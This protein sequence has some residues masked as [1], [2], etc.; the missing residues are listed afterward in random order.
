MT[1]EWGLL[2]AAVAMVAALVAGCGSDGAR[3]QP[4][5]STGSAVNTAAGADATA[6]PG[7]DCGSAGPVG[8]ADGKV[9]DLVVVTGHI[10]C[11]E[12]LAVLRKYE[13]GSV[14]K[15]GSGGFATFD[16]WNCSHGSVADIQRDGIVA[17]CERSDHSVAFHTKLVGGVSAS[18]S[19]SGGVGADCGSYGAGQGLIIRVVGTTTS[20]F[21]A[22]QVITL[23]SPLSGN[24]SPRTVLGWDCAAG[25][26]ALA[27][28]TNGGQT[29]KLVAGTSI[30]AGAS[31]GV[32][33][34]CGKDLLFGPEAPL[35]VRVGGSTPCGTAKALVD[36][37]FAQARVKQGYTATV[38]G[39][40]C[41]WG[42][43]LLET[44]EACIRG[45][46]SVLLV[47]TAT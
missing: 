5:P 17:G 44:I 47:R 36:K 30:A 27:R 6:G 29:I 35:R 23:Y 21:V 10:R 46:E 11:G 22:T 38:D 13:S 42:G 20:C 39:W 28:C 3:R 43:S 12:A 2:A 19:P 4:V 32:G 16:G 9:A 45:D 37:F 7:T 8:A 15:E 26:D 18:P 25:Q 31:S 1:G 24:P 33:T 40:L 34:D 14:R 41:S